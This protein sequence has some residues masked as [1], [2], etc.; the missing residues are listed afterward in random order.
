M[1][2]HCGEYDR[3]A[4]A[5]SA[6]GIV[7]LYMTGAHAAFELA[8]SLPRV[9]AHSHMHSKKRS[10]QLD[11]TLAPTSPRSSP[12]VSHALVIWCEHAKHFPCRV[13]RC[14]SAS[15]YCCSFLSPSPSHASLQGT[16]GRRRGRLW[17]E[18]ERE[19]VFWRGKSGHVGLWWEMERIRE[20]REEEEGG[21]GGR[22]GCRVM[23]AG[24][25]NA[26]WQVSASRC[27]R[28]GHTHPK[29]TSYR[30]AECSRA[31]GFIVESSI[32]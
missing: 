26:A 18:R 14:R 32:W 17:R 9:A 16:G 6:L 21:R 30:T 22:W 2:V 13:Q 20:E 19:L 27:E 23:P 29:K 4:A 31:T 24:L 7:H 5:A 15:C 12:P 11:A 10:R 8:P 3:A 1:C 28:H 25:R